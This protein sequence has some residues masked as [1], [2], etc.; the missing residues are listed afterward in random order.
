MALKAL[1]QNGF[2]DPDALAMVSRHL[3]VQ[4]YE[5]TQFD[6][7]PTLIDDLPLAPDVFIFAPLWVT[8]RLLDRAG[9]TGQLLPSYPESLSDHLHRALWQG[10]FCD[11]V[12]GPAAQQRPV[13][14]KT[15]TVAG[16]IGPH[17]VGA[18]ILASLDA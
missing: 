12:S 10:R 1:I 6:P 15:R 11:L 4:G 7:E 17:G 2:L 18:Q 9:L 3:L 16:R 13:F 5:V 14:I 8:L